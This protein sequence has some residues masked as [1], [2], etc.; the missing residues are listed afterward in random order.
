MKKNIASFAIVYLILWIQPA[1][2]YLDPGSGSVI[3]SAI[4]GFIVA[5]G[6]V[7][8]TYWYKIISL[9]KGKK[10]DFDSDTDQDREQ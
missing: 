5:S 1:M 8:K 3:M 2:A 7:V 10:R 4:V 6:L 9:F